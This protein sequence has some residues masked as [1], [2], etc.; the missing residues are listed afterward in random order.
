MLARPA[1]ASALAQS[2]EVSS[3]VGP[4]QPVSRGGASVAARFSSVWTAHHLRAAKIAAPELLHVCVF[5][6]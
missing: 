4:Q 1:E 3:L 5:L 6:T 2:A